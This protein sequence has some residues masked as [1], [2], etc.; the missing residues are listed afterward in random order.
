MPRTK[1]T[2]CRDDLA[3]A[4]PHSALALNAEGAAP[5]WAHLLPAGPRITGLDGRSWALNAQG[6]VAACQRRGLPL[7]IDYEHGQDLRATAGEAAPAAGWIEELQLRDD[8]VWGRVSWTP[9]GAASVINRE[10]RFLSPA[11]TYDRAS[12]AVAELIGAGLVNRPNLRLTALNREEPSMHKIIADALGLPETA[13]E[14]E[15]AAAIAAMKADRDVALNRAATPDLT[16]F[17]PRADLELA[18]NRAGVAEAKL[19]EIETAA[20]EDAI[21]SAVE[22]AVKAGKIAPA[23]KDFYVATCREDGGL[24]RFKTL[25]ET[26]PSVFDR[27]TPQTPAGDKAG[28]GVALNSEQKHVAAMLG[29]AEA[30]FAKHLAA[31]AA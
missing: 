19:R 8:G 9:A 14:Q 20:R 30:D 18:L 24:D 16:K 13:T 26:L 7:A 31:Q 15:A 28:A 3:A 12:A 22:S 29:I 1:A 2:P 4:A 10:Y 21:N 27:A 5:D 25:V 6:V 11:F 17:A 23:S